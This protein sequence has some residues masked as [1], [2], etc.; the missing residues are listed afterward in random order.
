MT[1]RPVSYTVTA[2]DFA[3][4]AKQLKELDDGGVLRRQFGRDIRNLAKKIVEAEKRAALG[5]KSEGAK[6]TTGSQGQR[7]LRESTMASRGIA[8][9]SSAKMKR[10]VGLGLSNPAKAQAMY[11]RAVSSGGLRASIANSMKYVVRYQGKDV[12][13]RIRASRSSMP[14]GMASMPRNVNRG[15]WRH[16]VY[17]YQQ[18]WVVQRTAPK[19]W[20][21]KTGDQFREPFKEE[22][23]KTVAAYQQQLAARIT[24]AGQAK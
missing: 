1:D 23:A 9:M 22:F 5:V 4:V 3:A 10:M 18:S 21:Y 12:G 8:R 2:A 11:D 24:Q 19:N 7:A 15:Q 17:G 16:P 13:V 14:P 6:R 20:F